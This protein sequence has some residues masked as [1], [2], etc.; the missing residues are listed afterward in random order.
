MD[1]IYRDLPGTASREPLSVWNWKDVL[2]ISAGSIFFLILG[3]FILNR[4]AVFDLGQ[5]SPTESSSLVYNVLLAGFE[6]I[7][8]VLSV[9]ILGLRRKGLSWELIGLRKPSSSWLWASTLSSFIFIP[10][11]GLIALLIQKVLGLP[12]QNPQLPFL[13]PENFTWVGALGMILL[14]GLAVPFAEELFFRGVLYLWLRRRLGFWPALLLSSLI[15]G[16]LHGDVSVAGATFV[17]GL[18]LGWFYER[19]KSLWSP[20]IIHAMN[21]SIKLVLLYTLIATGVTIPGIQ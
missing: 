8:L 10:L 1:E 7:A 17:M 15:F 18:A 12:E 19:S 3:I 16:F 5:T 14:G 9:Y 2:L 6:S 20:I 21:N 13:A 4:Q 11:M